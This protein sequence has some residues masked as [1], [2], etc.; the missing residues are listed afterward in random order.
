MKSRKRNFMV[1]GE[2]GTRYDWHFASYCLAA[3][4]HFIHSALSQPASPF[5]A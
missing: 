3:E 2:T 5:S 1:L 4:I